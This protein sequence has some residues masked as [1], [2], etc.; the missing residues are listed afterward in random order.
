MSIAEWQAWLYSRLKVYEQTGR[1]ALH[2]TLAFMKR[3]DE[4]LGA[5]HRRYPIIH[6]AG[7]NG[8]GST[9]A[10]IASILRAAGYRVGLHTSPHLWRFTERMRVNGEEPP[11]E[12]VDEFLSRWRAAIEELQLSFFEATV[13]MSLA[14]FAD[15]KVDVAVVEVGLGGRWDA[16]NI[17]TPLLAVITPI[18]WDHVEVLGPT[19]THIAR[20]KAGIIKPERPVVVAQQEHPEVYE[21]FRE[22]AHNQNA[23]LTEVHRRLSPA[24]WMEGPQTYYRVFTEEMTSTS[25]LCDLTGDYQAVNIATAITAIERLRDL[26]WSVDE[27]AIKEGIA[28]AGR[29]APLY[30]RGQWIRSE[31]HTYLLD[32]AHN[33]PGFAALR[34]LVRNAPQTIEGLVIGFSSDKDIEGALHAFGGWQGPVYF[35]QADNPRALPAPHLAEIAS[36]LGYKGRA[37]RSVADALAAASQECQTILVTGSV[38]LV[39]EALL[40]LRAAAQ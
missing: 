34:R 18:G 37:F 39:G 36:H 33:P 35:T 23:P 10:L 31:T 24:A 16:T 6:I 14:Y 1:K 21:V 28:S 3:W 2:P 7:T 12:W 38:Y 5:P 40:A 22:V 13:G 26:G 19:L 20:E 27:E 29:L 30:G 15:A 4:V 32:V 8:K 11:A 9:S 25:H 17:V